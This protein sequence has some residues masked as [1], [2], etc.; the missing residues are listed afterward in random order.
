MSL[1][2]AFSVLSGVFLALGF[3]LARRRLTVLAVLFFVGSSA[4]SVL[5][6]SGEAARL[7]RLRKGESAPHEQGLSDTSRPAFPLPVEAVA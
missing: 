3:F 2:L 1:A 4:S 5:L 7:D 6:L